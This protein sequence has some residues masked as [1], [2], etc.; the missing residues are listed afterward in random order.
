MIKILKINDENYQEIRNFLTSIAPK[1]YLNYKVSFTCKECGKEYTYRTDTFLK[2]QEGPENLI[3]GRCRQSKKLKTF[4]A[5]NKEEWVGRQQE[6]IINTY[7]VTNAA[8]IPDA[9][10]KKKE[11]CLEKYGSEYAINSLEV[12]SKI[13][14]TFQEK[15]NGN[16]PFCDEK[17]QDKA[18]SSN[19]KNHGGKLFV[20]TPE[21]QKIRET[22][23]LEK[24]GLPYAFS[25]EILKKKQNT[26]LQKY[27]VKEIF[28]LPS[29][30]EKRK[31]VML[32]R[33]GVEFSMQDPV[34]RSLIMQNFYKN[35]NRKGVQKG[36]TY[37]GI[38]FDSS[39]ELTYYLWLKSKNVDF[40]VHPSTMF[41]YKDDK[42]K[43][44]TYSPDFKVNGLFV[45]I[46]GGQFF[47]KNNNP[48]SIYSGSWQNKYNCILDNNIILLREKD[49]QEPFDYVKF[50]FGNNF[51]KN[52]RNK[53]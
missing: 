5:N 34:W 22:T 20:E 40:E 6:S 17:I 51:I 8:Y 3:C 14:K 53:K 19:R 24:Y 7:G 49:L 46:K 33:Y 45:E 13:D 1:D 39:Y 31:E 15:Y 38:N 44:H 29:F 2:M 11:T 50:N 9:Q 18:Q 35:T 32:E 37:D 43:N 12:R 23:C 30:W 42:G 16:S 36:Y 48:I 21:F 27:G 47:D 41:N 4:I 25:P 26:N 52:C 28:Y 10:K